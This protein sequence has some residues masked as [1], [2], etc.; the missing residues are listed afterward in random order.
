MLIFNYLYVIVEAGLSV[1]LLTCSKHLWHNTLYSV[2]EMFFHNGYEKH[3]QVQN[4][5][6]STLS[7]LLSAIELCSQACLVY[8]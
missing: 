2:A 5:K 3:T 6:Y 7:V 8:F 4:N 1:D